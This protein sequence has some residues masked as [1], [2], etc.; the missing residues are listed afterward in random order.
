MLLWFIYSKPEVCAVPHGL[1]AKSQKNHITTVTNN[2]LQ[3]RKKVQLDRSRTFNANKKAQLCRLLQVRQDISPLQGNSTLGVKLKGS[4]RTVQNLLETKRE[5]E[6]HCH[7]N[8][9]RFLQKK[10]KIKK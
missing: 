7:V 3:L 10:K 8:S 6:F 9:A 5:I 1:T 4:T 2:F